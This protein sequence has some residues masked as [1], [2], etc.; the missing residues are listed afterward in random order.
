[1]FYFP[2]CTEADV[3]RVLVT[4]ALKIL[5]FKVTCLFWIFLLRNLCLFFLLKHY[6][7]TRSS[8]AFPFPLFRLF[9][10]H[11]VR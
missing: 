11:L 4:V 8:P 5:L 3:Y 7:L 10:D 6:I 1:M 2:P 9:Y